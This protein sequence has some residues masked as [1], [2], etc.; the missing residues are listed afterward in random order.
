MKIRG[1]DVNVDV[2]YELK[3]FKWEQANWTDGSKL[4]ACSPF[5]PDDRKA[6]WFIRL[7]TEGEY[8]AGIWMDSGG[9]DAEFTKGGFVKL[10]AYLHGIDIESAEDL[11]LEQYHS[12]RAELVW[13][14]PSFNLKKKKKYMSEDS[15]LPFKDDNIYLLERNIRSDIIERFGCGYS[16]QKNVI[17]IPWRTA[18][19][20]LSNVKFRKASKKEKMFWYSKDGI[21]INQLIWGL[22]AIYQDGAKTAIICESEIDAL[23]SWSY[24]VA[25]IA[26]G[27]GAFSQER[28]DK[29]IRSPLETVIIATDNDLV[30]NRIRKSIEARLRGSMKILHL[31]IP[32]PYKDI[33]DIRKQDEFMELY[34]KVVNSEKKFSF[35]KLAI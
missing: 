18:Q 4:I 35:K 34:T 16:K 6:S 30:G 11:L 9:I 15:L 13:R 33:N 26:I 7:K 2:T 22:D 24:G 1:R 20:R 25:A 31:H 8:E 28:A 14:P 3:Q 32:A 29:I 5:R 10:Y 19:G 23:Q 17:A 12:E 27:G 21:P